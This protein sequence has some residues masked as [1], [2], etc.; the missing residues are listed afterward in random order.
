MLIFTEDLIMLLS[1]QKN[2]AAIAENVN[3][4]LKVDIRGIRRHKGV[5]RHAGANTVSTYN[6]Q[7]AEKQL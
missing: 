2:R 7:H 1:F 5:L 6:G 3:T 4:Q